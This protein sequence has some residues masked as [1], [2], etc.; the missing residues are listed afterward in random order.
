MVN[1]NGRKSLSP[2]WRYALPGAKVN[3]MVSTQKTFLLKEPN[4]K[5]AFILPAVRIIIATLA[6]ENRFSINTIY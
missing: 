2:G 4:T 3:N 1:A 6:H 5:S